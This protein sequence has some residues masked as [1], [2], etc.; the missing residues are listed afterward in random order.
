MSFVVKLAVGALSAS[1]ALSVSAQQ[2]A[3]PA[4]AVQT[5]PSGGAD[6]SYRLAPRDIIVVRVYREEDL[7]TDAR[8][9]KNGTITFPLIGNIHVVGLT[10]QQAAQK[11]A[12]ALR[13]D[14][15]IDPQVSVGVAEYSVRRI[16]VLGQV[17]RPGTF[18]MPDDASLNLLEAIGMAGGFTRIARPTRVTVKRTAEGKE[19][20]FQLN[21]KDMARDQSTEP[22]EILPGDTITVAESL[23]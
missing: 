11:I 2:P 9:D 8:I 15:L 1:A 5:G 3:D 23:F 4:P 22:F 21:A 16:T 12:K 13:G 7:N 19:L 18:E 10:P 14:Y 6:S 20:T 17:A